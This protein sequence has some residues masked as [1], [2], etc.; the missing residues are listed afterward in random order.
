MRMNIHSLCDS[1]FIVLFKRNLISRNSESTVTYRRVILITTVNILGDV[2][3]ACFFTMNVQKQRYRCG[4]ISL[5]SC[6]IS[7]QTAFRMVA[8]SE[9]NR[10]QRLD[11]NTRCEKFSHVICNATDYSCAHA[12]HV[13]PH[14]FVI[15]R[16]PR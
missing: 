16:A 12:C 5:M 13:C 14:T 2:R 15:L 10:K 8:T 1:V 4:T 3:G 11:S 7:Q 6:S 9:I